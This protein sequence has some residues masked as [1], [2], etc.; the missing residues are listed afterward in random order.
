MENPS[1]S[2]SSYATRDSTKCH[3]FGNHSLFSETM[4]PTY[5]DVMQEFL[6]LRGKQRELS[7]KNPPINPMFEKIADKIH[8]IYEKASIPT[9]SKNRTM[10]KL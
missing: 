5:S 1:P 9:V 8:D 10:S 3:I 4:L 7:K 6:Y 2:T